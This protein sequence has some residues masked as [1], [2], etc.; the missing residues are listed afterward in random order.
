MGSVQ[1]NRRRERSRHAG[2]G[3]ILGH[4]APPPVL[5]RIAR[6]TERSPRAARRGEPAAGE[7]RGGGEARRGL[8]G[9]SALL[10]KVEEEASEEGGPEAEAGGCPGC[11]VAAIVHC[12]GPCAGE[13][14][15]ARQRRALRAAPSGHEHAKGTLPLPAV[16]RPL[17]VP[18]PLPHAGHLPGWMR[19]V[20]FP[21]GGWAAEGITGIGV[22]SQWCRGGKRGA[23]G[24]QALAAC[25]P[26]RVPRVGNRPCAGSGSPGTS[27]HV[28]SVLVNEGPQGG[29]SQAGRGA[30]TLG[31]GHGVAG[32]LPGKT[33]T[34]PLSVIPR[35]A[36]ESTCHLGSP[37]QLPQD[38]VSPWATQSA[39]AVCSIPVGYAPPPP[40]RD[41]ASSTVPTCPRR[42][43]TPRA[44]ERPKEMP[45]N[46][47]GGIYG[48]LETACHR[49][50]D[51]TRERGD[52]VEKDRPRE[53]RHRKQGNA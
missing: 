38:S 2:D 9:P 21:F 7:R 40:A 36:P 43:R 48:H 20:T 49:L 30:G 19:A 5:R 13:T 37:P 53:S 17:C 14:R 23:R 33:L 10:S 32:S 25:H 51:R 28:L 11:R 52:G 46:W 6:L 44:R 27:S 24:T 35:G 22:G 39:V 42:V 8:P 3:A 41:A 15:R 1:R 45:G 31:R 12:S 26:W 4:S 29:R 47:P 16:P 50:R 18:P 34:V